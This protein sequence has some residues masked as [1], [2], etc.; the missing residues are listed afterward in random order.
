MSSLTLLKV[1][2]PLLAATVNVPL[3]AAG[4]LATASVTLELSVVTMFPN[5][6]ST[7]TTIDGLS[8]TP[9]VTLLG[10]WS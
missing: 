3:S 7:S 6:S 2:T 4:P 5:W 1:A 9:A 10:C 8:A